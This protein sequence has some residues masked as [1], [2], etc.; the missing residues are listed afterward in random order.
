I[1]LRRE[2]VVTITPKDS[3]REG[4]T[5]QIHGEVLRPG[6]IPYRDNMTLEDAIIL[7]GGLKESASDAS[8]EVT[9]RLSYEEATKYGEANVHL[10]QF[11]ISR[12]LTIDNTDAGF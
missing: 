11:N 2:D 12:L 6:E 3:I 7:A 9:R 10:Y 5:I 8:I 4:R 1:D